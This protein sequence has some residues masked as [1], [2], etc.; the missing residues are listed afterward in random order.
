MKR[1]LLLAFLIVFPASISLG[2]NA[3]IDSLLNLLN[4]HDDPVAVDVADTFRLKLFIEIANES[5][6]LNYK[7]ITNSSLYAEFALNEVELLHYQRS[8]RGAIGESFVNLKALDEAM[9]YYKQLMIL[10][11]KI[12]DKHKAATVFNNIGHIYYVRK[13]YLTA[14]DYFEKALSR[15]P[16]HAK[17]HY[18]RGLIYYFNGKLDLAMEDFDEAIAINREF[19]SAYYNRGIIYFEQNKL[20]DAIS[21]FS[22][23]LKNFPLHW[24]AHYNRGLAFFKQERYYYAMWDLDKVIKLQP[25]FPDAYNTKANIYFLHEKFDTSIIFYSMALK[26]DS[27]LL[28]AYYNR[29]KAKFRLELYDESIADMD[30]AIAMDPQFGEAFYSRCHAYYLK[31]EYTAA[32]H[33]ILYAAS[34]GVKVDQKI[35]D[36]LQRLGN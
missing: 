3:R 28:M 9:R 12:N 7:D 10:F 33:N 5:L 29:G 14:L 20:D 13:D 23:T 18:N 34:F 36:E 31:G 19:Y 6:R 25:D 16:N 21:D 11:A 26:R 24:N 17:A 4:V 30:I 8:T 22:Y 1:I 2:Q 32:L 27:T 15:D 35:M